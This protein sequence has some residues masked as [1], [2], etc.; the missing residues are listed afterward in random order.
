MPEGKAVVMPGASF[1]YVT[2]KILSV[3]VVFRS[4]ANIS[5]LSCRSN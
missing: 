5:V 2:M 1:D 4:A 3:A